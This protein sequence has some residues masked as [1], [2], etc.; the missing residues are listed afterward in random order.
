MSYQDKKKRKETK[1]QKGQTMRLYSKKA[2][3]FL[4]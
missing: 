1:T 4:D 2:V 3:S